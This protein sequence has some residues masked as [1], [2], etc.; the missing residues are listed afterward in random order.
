MGDSGPNVIQEYKGKEKYFSLMLCAGGKKG[1]GRGGG[2]RG[3]RGVDFGLGIGY[4]PESN[5]S[6]SPDATSRSA[7]VNSL[8]TGVMAQFKSSFVA[9]SS[10]S[11]SPGLN[12]S[13]SASANKRPALRG[14]VSGGS[15]GG[16]INR[17]QTTSSLP[18]FVS[19]GDATRT[20]TVNQTSGRNTSQKNTEGYVYL[21]PPDFAV[22]E[23]EGERGGGPLV[24]TVK[25][26]K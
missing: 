11:Q 3:V 6:S 23:I 8:R 12:N 25:L 7:A 4:N 13:S 17:P 18:G 24:G 26:M 10:N 21:L 14:F 19:G 5:N 22:P 1:K 15:I 9:A 20:Q 2:G 16:E